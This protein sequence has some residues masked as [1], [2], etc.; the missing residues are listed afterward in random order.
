M[1][2]YSVGLPNCKPL[3]L[4]HEYFCG[5]KPDSAVAFRYCDGYIMKGGE[6]PRM[7]NFV[8]GLAVV[9][10]SKWWEPDEYADQKMDGN[11]AAL[12]F[13]A[14]NGRAVAVFFGGAQPGRVGGKGQGAAF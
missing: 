13:G 8:S 2:Y 7:A 10:N 5:F 14:G 9:S 1:D 3:T 11:G 6:G 4:F 12:W